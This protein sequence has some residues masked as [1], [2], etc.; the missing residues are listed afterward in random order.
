MGTKGET[1]WVGGG[2]TAGELFG[3]RLDS[4]QV[5]KYPKDTVRLLHQNASTDA[6]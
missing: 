1:I 2:E 6:H 3:K 5:P 4:L